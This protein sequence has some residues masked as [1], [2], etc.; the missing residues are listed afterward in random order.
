LRRNCGSFIYSIFASPYD[1]KTRI[2]LLLNAIFEPFWDILYHFHYY[3]ERYEY[4]CFPLLFKVNCIGCH[5]CT[6]N[7][8]PL[9]QPPMSKGP[10]KVY[11]GELFDQQYEAAFGRG[12]LVNLWAKLDAHNETVDEQK[13]NVGSERT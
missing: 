10:W 7:K 8:K 5:G 3:C 1:S 2:G 12:E 9:L 11:T 4:S 13:K 6:N